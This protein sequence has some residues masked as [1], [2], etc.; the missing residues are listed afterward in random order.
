MCFVCLFVGCF[1][2]NYFS[3]SFFCVLLLLLFRWFNFRNP[4]A[5][6][7]R[8]TNTHTQLSDVS[9]LLFLLLLLYCLFVCVFFCC[10]FLRKKFFFLLIKCLSIDSRQ[11]FVVVVNFSSSLFQQMQSAAITAIIRKLKYF[12][13]EL[14]CCNLNV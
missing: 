6:I 11:D 13:M 7:N 8:Q 1:W 4:T 3:S 2:K 14:K 9:F 5:I 10:L 12:F